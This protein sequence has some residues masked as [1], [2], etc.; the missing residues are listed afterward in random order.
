[1]STEPIRPRPGTARH[2][3]LKA[4]QAC[5][6]L[7]LEL[8]LECRGWNQRDG[9]HLQ[10][11]LRRASFSAAASI[12]EGAAKRGAAEFRRYLDIANG[13]L[14]ELSYA[15]ILARDLGKLDTARYGELEALRDHAGQLTWGLYAAIS[16]RARRPSNPPPP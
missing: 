9:W 10:D 5:H 1:M 16:R 4:W 12:A 8:H 6:Q 15:L 11:Q 2:A 14:A 7:A 3:Q 13:S